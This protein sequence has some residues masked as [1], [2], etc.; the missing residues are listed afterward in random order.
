MRVTDFFVRAGV[1]HGMASINYCVACSAVRGPLGSA[2]S[3]PHLS[4]S[5]DD[6]CAWQSERSRCAERIRE[7]PVGTDNV[8]QSGQI[9]ECEWRR[10]TAMGSRRSQMPRWNARI[11]SIVP[12]GLMLG[13]SRGHS[14]RGEPMAYC[15][16]RNCCCPVRAPGCIDLDSSSVADVGF[17]GFPSQADQMRTAGGSIGAPRIGEEEGSPRTF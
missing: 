6:E 5:G 1:R 7:S 9:N 12:A 2:G 15:D 3:S 13:M 14:G 8:W 10:A 4:A 16:P 17:T 11:V